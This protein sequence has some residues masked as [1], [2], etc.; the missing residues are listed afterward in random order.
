[1]APNQSLFVPA[2]CMNSLV[3]TEHPSLMR[4]N[5]CRRSM[6]FGHL[7]A[8]CYSSWYGTLMAGKELIGSLS[9]APKKE[10]LTGSSFSTTS[11][12]RST[13]RTHGLSRRSSPC[14]TYVLVFLSS[15]KAGATTDHNKEFDL[16]RE[17]PNCT[18]FVLDVLQLIQSSMLR[19]APEKRAG[20]D[21][22]VRQLEVIAQCCDQD[23][24]YCTQRS[25]RPISKTSSD[26]SEIVPVTYSDNTKAEL[27]SINAYNPQA[28]GPK[29]DGRNLID[30]TR[31]HAQD[32]NVEIS[33]IY[34]TTS[35]DE[36]TAVQTPD[37]RSVS[38]LA[39]PL[40]NDH[41]QEREPE[42][43]AT[44]PTKWKISVWLRALFGV[45]FGCLRR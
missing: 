24:G 40:S 17:H 16:I 45:C 20:C 13:R 15:C 18:D 19:M 7:D 5:V 36:R 10:K 39:K 37:D 35:V 33:T 41:T 34:T 26:L 4:S 9:G 22:I 38:G 2:P 1:M 3:P 43:S 21:A 6:I 30:R 27:A 31:L 23:A 25:I 29:G 42:T 12:T 32:A 8:S 14:E 11:S 28:P 44:A